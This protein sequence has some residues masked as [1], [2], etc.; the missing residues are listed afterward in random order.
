MLSLKLILKYKNVN[1][2]GCV[3]SLPLL[4]ITF[5]YH[6]LI[7]I[8]SYIYKNVLSKTKS[9]FPAISDDSLP[10]NPYVEIFCHVFRFP[11]LSRW[12]ETLLYYVNIMQALLSSWC[13]QETVLFKTRFITWWYHCTSNVLVMTIFRVLNFPKIEY[14]WI[15]A[16]MMMMIIMW[17]TIL[18][19]NSF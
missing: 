19:H 7:R 4:Y 1:N 5:R 9:N 6:Y 15:E 2:K 14:F 16:H 10:L 18:L 17:S 11:D 13:C 8:L 3:D 12:V